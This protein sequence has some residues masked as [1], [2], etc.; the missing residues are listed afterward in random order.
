LLKS[1]LRRSEEEFTANLRENERQLKSL[2]DTALSL[3]SSR[4]VALD[5]RRLQ[6]VEKL[7]TAK[8]ATDRM[9][10]AAA[11]ISQLNLDEMFKAANSGEPGIEKF[12][13]MLDQLTGLDLRKEVPQ[14]SA[15]SERPFLPPNVWALFAAYQGVM[16]HS[17]MSL[18]VLSMGT[19]EFFKRDDTL[20]PLML[21][22][23]PEYKNYIEKY[24]FSGYYHLLDAL[25][26]KLLTALSEMLDGKDV[27]DATIKRSAE[28]MS[29]VRAQ[30]SGI[31]LNIP[32]SLR[33]PDIPDPRNA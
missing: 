27:D 25:E 17:V 33:G 20:K 9:K 3:R 13:G 7:W 11:M 24:G 28:I 15:V 12:A 6:A 31:K 32:D 22:A 30:E 18:K 19:A 21:V 1:E 23:L 5:G 8:I 29:A 2:T 26:E 4:Q 10:M 16:L 14:A